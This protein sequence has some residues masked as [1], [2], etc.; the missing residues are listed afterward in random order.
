MI[1]IN[2]DQNTI[3]VWNGGLPDVLVVTAQG[4][5]RYRIGSGHVPLGILDKGKFDGTLKTVSAESGDCMYAYSDGIIEAFN[6]M[7]EMFGQEG[8]EAALACPSTAGWR[9]DGVVETINMF[10]RGRARDDDFTISEVKFT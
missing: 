8:L 3:A 7:D 9:I 5:I 2:R 1:E 4:E 10:C 6:P